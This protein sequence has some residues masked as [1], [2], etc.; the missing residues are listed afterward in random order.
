MVCK[1]HLNSFLKIGGC[2]K[3]NK[4]SFFSIKRGFY[5]SSTLNFCG[6]IFCVRYSNLEGQSLGW[7]ISRSHPK[8]KLRDASVINLSTVRRGQ[9]LFIWQSI[10][11]P[12]HNKNRPRTVLR[13][14]DPYSLR[15]GGS[16]P[17]R[18]RGP[19]CLKENYLLDFQ[20]T[21]SCLDQNRGLGFDNQSDQYTHSSQHLTLHSSQR[22]C[23]PRRKHSPEHLQMIVAQNVNGTIPTNG[24]LPQALQSPRHL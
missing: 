6:V 8:L 1:L 11:E 22:L 18:T 21:V 13:G 24:P 17:N 4:R 12:G 15:L 14:Q 9:D 23:R 2:Q 10:D 7:D 5:S 20:D 3:S 19:G 16:H